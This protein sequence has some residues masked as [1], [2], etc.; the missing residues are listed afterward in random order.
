MIRRVAVAV[1]GSEASL[2]AMAWA[3]RM[4]EPGG[5]VIGIDVKELA[6]IYGQYTTEAYLGAVVT[7]ELD[8]DWDAEAEAL[9]QRLQQL[10]QTHNVHT[11]WE[12]VTMDAGD[13]L[14]AAGFVRRA[15]S[16]GAEALVVGQHRGFRKVEE[17]FGSFSR[18]VAGHS[19]LPTI[20]VPAPEAPRSDQ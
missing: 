8:R 4:V 11:H 2:A 17:L 14:P 13:G 3:V 10:G 18:Y 7:D 20:I 15:Q 12:V 1:D 19:R 6:N 16:L 9:G 5:T